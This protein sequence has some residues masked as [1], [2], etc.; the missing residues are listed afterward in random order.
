[1]VGYAENVVL[2]ITF[3]ELPVIY[4]VKRSQ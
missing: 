3:I 1:M 4:A 2:L